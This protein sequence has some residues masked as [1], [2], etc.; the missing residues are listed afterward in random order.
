MPFGEWCSRRSGWP[1]RRG[2]DG[3]RDSPTAPKP[4]PGRGRK[5]GRRAAVRPARLQNRLAFGGAAGYTS[6]RNSGGGGGYA[7]GRNMAHVKTAI[8][9][10]EKLFRR[11]NELAAEMHVSRSRLVAVALEKLVKA[12]DEEELVR[13]IREAYADFPN[14]EEKA[15]LDIGAAGLAELTKDDTW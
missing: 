2:H 7:D 5:V 13:R 14:E 15:F 9:L 6:G 10:D 1:T 3:K 12:H 4:R 8:S 11:A